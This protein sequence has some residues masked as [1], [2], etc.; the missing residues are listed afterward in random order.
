M[1]EQN[2]ENR[3]RIEELEGQ[4]EAQLH[5]MKILVEDMEM[6]DEHY[7]D[8][9]QKCQLALS[10][11]ESRKIEVESLNKVIFLC[12]LCVLTSLTLITRA[13]CMIKEFNLH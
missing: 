6:M 13:L 9:Y 5:Q 11:L 3:V 2:E 12:Y 1:V 4:L 8:V 10:K 7:R